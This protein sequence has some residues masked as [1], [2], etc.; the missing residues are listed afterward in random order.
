MIPHFFNLIMIVHTSAFSYCYGSA[1]DDAISVS[2]FYKLISNTSKYKDMPK[3]NSEFFPPEI[4]I[5][6]NQLYFTSCHRND[7]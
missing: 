2:F 7:C 4:L 6:K 1:T 5:K 3:Y